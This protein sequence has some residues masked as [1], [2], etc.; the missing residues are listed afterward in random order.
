MA[1]RLRVLMPSRQHQQE[2]RRAERLAVYDKYKARTW[3]GMVRN[4]MLFRRYR[5]LGKILQRKG[6]IPANRPGLR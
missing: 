3:L 6:I 2:N 4:K 1:K 5:R